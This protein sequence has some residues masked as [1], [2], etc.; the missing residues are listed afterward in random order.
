MSF[1]NAYLLTSTQQV[2]CALCLSKYVGRNFFREGGG[3]TSTLLSKIK[4]ELFSLPRS[5]HG[6]RTW[7]S[8]QNICSHRKFSKKV[9]WLK[10]LDFFRAG[11]SRATWHPSLRTCIQSSSYI[12][13]CNYYRIPFAAA[14]KLL[15]NYGLA[16]TT[17][18]TL[19]TLIALALVC[20]LHHKTVTNVVLGLF[21]STKLQS[22]KH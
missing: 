8:R 12:V 21:G 13:E 10:I 17:E 5:G 16:F 22:R 6:G 20:L 9:I 14:Q 4:M 1:F 2:Q 19:I 15:T 11:K 7:K 18:I 3:S